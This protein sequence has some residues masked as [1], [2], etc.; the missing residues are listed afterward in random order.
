MC[1]CGV[2]ERGGHTIGGKKASN[3]GKCGFDDFLIL[4]DGFQVC[5]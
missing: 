5:W 1:M 3:H 4:R 2:C